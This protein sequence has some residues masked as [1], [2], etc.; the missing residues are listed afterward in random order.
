MGGIISGG[1]QFGTAFDRASSAK[2]ANDYE[3]FSAQRA[4]E[5]GQLE[6][7]QDGNFEAGKMRM[8]ATQLIARQ[9]TAYAASGVDPTQGT[10]VSVMADTRL[11]AEQD[12]LIVENNAAR[13]VRGHK[14]QG[15]YAQRTWQTKNTEIDNTRTGDLVGGGASMLSGFLTGFGGFG[16]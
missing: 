9:R 10:P 11:L 5:T 16:G 15:E 4:A 8:L 7:Q 13:K 12:A 6:A 3:L 1:Y 14:L 2:A